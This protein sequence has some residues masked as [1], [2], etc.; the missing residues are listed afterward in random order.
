MEKPPPFHSFEIA[1]IMFQRLR[2]L[3]A[4]PDGNKEICELVDYVYYGC[5]E[6][7]ES[8]DP[9]RWQQMLD[10]VARDLDRLWEFSPDPD[11]TFL[12][13]PQ[14]AVP[15]LDRFL[16][17]P[18]EPALGKGKNIRERERLRNKINWYFEIDSGT[19]CLLATVNHLYAHGE[20]EA[21]ENVISQ[22]I[23]VPGE[24]SA[25]SHRVDKAYIL[26][27]NIKE[28]TINDWSF[29]GDSDL[30]ISMADA[31]EPLVAETQARLKAKRDLALQ[32]LSDALQKILTDGVEAEA[33]LAI[34]QVQL[35]ALKKCYG[36]PYPKSVEIIEKELYLTLID[37]FDI[38][39][40]ELDREEIE[41]S[42]RSMLIGLDDV[43]F[44]GDR[45]KMMALAAKARPLVAE[46]HR[47]RTAQS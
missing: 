3:G 24:D 5:K 10:D 34:F 29:L 39:G 28:L 37:A 46:L 35:E 30:L 11:V 2:D 7:D 20:D 9:K 27:S 1:C 26:W 25:I 8:S 21:A 6:L 33:A 15:L 17:N 19:E 14:T 23:G 4:N 32:W 31:A 45:E 22:A 38:L 40:N 16:E 36:R 44:L 18:S 41:D 43:S 12:S 42:L 13:D 47:R